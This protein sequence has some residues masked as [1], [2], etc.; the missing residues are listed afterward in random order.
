MTEEKKHLEATLL[1]PVTADKVGLGLKKQKIGK[2]LLNGWGGLVDPG[3]TPLECAVRETFEEG[4]VKVDA[5]TLIKAAVILF[6]NE[7]F[8]CQVHVYLAPWSYGPLQETD[9]MGP[10]EWYDRLAP[11]VH[12]MMLADKDWLPLVLQGKHIRGEVWYGPNQE[13]LKGCNFQ[14]VEP[15]EL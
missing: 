7:K 15:H 13:S 12:H 6:H 1:L 4:G 8:D 14:Y 2:G 5:Q 3:E 9:E 11:P 10:I